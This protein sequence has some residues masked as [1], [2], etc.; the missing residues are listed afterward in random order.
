ML[1]CASQL[2]W[3][4][5]RQRLSVCGV[6][7]ESLHD[8][9]ELL[10]ICACAFESA[11]A[12]EVGG[13]VRRVG[14]GFDGVGVERLCHERDEVADDARVLQ[15]RLNDRVGEARLREIEIAR[16][17]GRLVRL[18]LVAHLHMAASAHQLPR[19]RGNSATCAVRSS[20]PTRNDVSGAR[21]SY[22]T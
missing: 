2:G 12:V 21:K 17:T 19:T 9:C 16:G 1:G 14:E 7:T 8:L 15:E 10:H 22:L 18:R 4:G 3:C 13:P 20:S 5:E 6:I 11:A